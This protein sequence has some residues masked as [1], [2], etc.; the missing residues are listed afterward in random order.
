MCN[1]HLFTLI[2]ALKIHV[3][4][5][6]IPINLHRTQIGLSGLPNLAAPYIFYF[7]LLALNYILKYSIW[8]ISYWITKSEIT[9]LGHLL[10]S[11]S[12]LFSNFILSP[13]IIHS[14]TLDSN[15]SI[16]L[17]F[18]HFSILHYNQFFCKSWYLHMHNISNRYQP[19]EISH[20][21]LEH[22]Y[23]HPSK[24]HLQMMTPDGPRDWSSTEFYL[25][26]E[27]NYLFNF[28]KN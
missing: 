9:G 22:Q 26:C 7:F 12:A 3:L 20:F 28:T 17:D 10:R 14:H 19:W 24:N 18:Y 2:Y 8:K 13:T 4:S 23:F 1:Y 25:I 6:T 16:N 21:C 15:I 11:P 5:Q 27:N